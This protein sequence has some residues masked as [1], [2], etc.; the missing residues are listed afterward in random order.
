LFVTNGSVNI[1]VTDDGAT[2]DEVPIR[3]GL[4][5]VKDR[6]LLAGGKMSIEIEPAGGMTVTAE[7]KTM[8]A[9]S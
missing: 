7:L 6:V 4:I 5:S 3:P 8:R 2:T 1:E 9:A